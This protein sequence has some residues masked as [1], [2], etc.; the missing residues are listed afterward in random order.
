M[1]GNFIIA[2]VTFIQK[3]LINTSLTKSLMYNAFEYLILNEVILL[4]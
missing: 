4:F 1:L 2:F 3:I